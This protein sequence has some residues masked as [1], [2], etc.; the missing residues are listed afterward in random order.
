MGELRKYSLAIITAC[1]PLQIV[2][3][4]VGFS[5]LLVRVVF[6]ISLSAY[7]AAALLRGSLAKPRT[8]LDVPLV[9][10]VCANLVVS[11]FARD[12]FLSLKDAG[13][14]LFLIVFF[15]F[16][17]FLHRTTADLGRTV[18]IY[19]G[20]ASLVAAY[21]IWQQLGFVFAW[22]TRLP[23]LEWFSYHRGVIAPTARDWA[24]S[25]FGSLFIRVRSTFLDTNILAGYLVSA[26]G[27]AVP[28]FFSAMFGPRTGEKM[29]WGVV[30]L[31][32]VT[33]VFLT[34]SRS[35]LI[36]LAVLL[37]VALFCYRRELFRAHLIWRLV[38]GIGLTAA[39]LFWLVPELFVLIKSVVSSFAIESKSTSRGG[40]A[41]YH[42]KIYRDGLRM[43]LDHP[44]TGV[45]LGNFR[46]VFAQMNPIWK[47]GYTNTQMMAHSVFL[48]FLAEG[49]LI[50][51]LVNYSIVGLV[52]VHIGQ[53]LRIAGD[54]RKRAYLVGSLCAYVG[55]MASQIFYQYYLMEFVW[56]VL[57][58]TVAATY[59]LREATSGEGMSSYGHP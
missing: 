46:V 13:L 55:L 10:L 48:S 57:A 12:T 22:D 36:G 8:F 14:Q 49:G 2:S 7:L 3:F 32:L 38:G 5:I 56:F 30:M 33:T 28:F 26:I 4:Y 45:G 51:G 58:F 44:L 19:I 59:L 25:D 37:A 42:L 34:M 41:Y 16:V 21:G 31:L 20:T 17:V 9:L 1:L 6:L 35:A 18:R 40:S 47:L 24:V 29:R 50:A 53:R 39:V 43:F 23:F 52:L 11:L 15:Y 27:L 54:G